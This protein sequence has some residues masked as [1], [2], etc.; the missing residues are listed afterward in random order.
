MRYGILSGTPVQNPEGVGFLPLILPL[1]AL[2]VWAGWK[3]A[4]AVTGASSGGDADALQPTVDAFK[5]CANQMAVKSGYRAV[6]AGPLL[7]KT[8]G[9]ANDPVST[10]C[11]SRDLIVKTC[12]ERS[13]TA[14]PLV[15]MTIEEANAAAVT[16]DEDEDVPFLRSRTALYLGL[17]LVAGLIYLQRRRAR[18]AMATVK[19]NARRHRRVRRSR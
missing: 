8:C 12:R 15:R 10:G 14:E 3:T 17:G 11:P 13:I 4:Q 6:P 16:E 7:G 9:L 1:L 19:R 5:T 2:P 18:K